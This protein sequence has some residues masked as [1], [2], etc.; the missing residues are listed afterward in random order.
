MSLTEANESKHQNK[1]R[2]ASVLNHLKTLNIPVIEFFSEF[3]SM[4]RFPSL[5]CGTFLQKLSKMRLKN[6]NYETYNRLR[7]HQSLNLFLVKL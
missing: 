7:V 5:E 4:A 2:T 6:V 3:S 1:Y